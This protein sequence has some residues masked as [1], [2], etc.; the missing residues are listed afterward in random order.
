MLTLGFDATAAVRQSAGIG[1]YTRQLLAG[2][3]CRTDLAV[4]LFYCAGG[5][6]GGRLPDLPPSTRV[7]ALPLSDRITNAVWHRVGLP[8]PVE[9]ILGRIDLFHSPDFTAPPTLGAP[10]VVTIHDLAFLTEPACAFPTLR[11]YL[12]RVVPRSARGADRII[13]VSDSTRRDVI[14]RF[15]IAPDKVTT[16]Y[17]AA[18]LE[19]YREPA[20]VADSVVG[21]MGITRPYILSVGTVEPR[22][23]YVRLLE[24]YARVL[25]QGAHQDL[26]IAG[27]F[28]WMFQPV[29]DTIAALRLDDRVR[30]V[31]PDDRQLRSLYNAADAFVYASLYEGFGIPVAEALACGA[32]VACGNTSSLPEVLGNAGLTFEPRDSE[33]IASATLRLLSDS[34]LAADFRRRGP[35]RAATFSWERAASETVAVYRAALD[36]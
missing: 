32:P 35:A 12:E 20:E 14:E 3:G 7:R 15:G 6:L 21:E 2:L 13:A 17:E 33:Q 22:K 18:G 28:G 27:H 9:A 29:L 5:S 36:G 10:R 1:R 23:N 26:V 19:F 24:A 11:A 30:I 25:A 4:R 8:V 34:R 16:V 31:S